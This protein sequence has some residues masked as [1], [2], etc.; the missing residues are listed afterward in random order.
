MLAADHRLRDSVSFR[1]T[2]RVGRR[3]GSPA[4]VV[5]LALERSGPARVGFVVNRSVGD[6]VTRNRVKRQ[7]RHLVSEDLDQLPSGA[8]LVVR[9]K[10]VAAGLSS[11]ELRA[12]LVGCLERVLPEAV[13]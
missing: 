6:A 9:A 1:R 7:L 10:P 13:R 3:A 4:L 2:V 5:H 11:S 8:D 12:E